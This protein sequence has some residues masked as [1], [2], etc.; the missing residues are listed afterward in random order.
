MTALTFRMHH[1][2]VFNDDVSHARTRA[3][4]ETLNH[5]L[6]SPPPSTTTCPRPGAPEL[7]G[8]TRWV[9]ISGILLHRWHDV[10]YFS[11]KWWEQT[12]VSTAAIGLTRFSHKWT[13]HVMADKSKRMK[14][15][16]LGGYDGSSARL[17]NIIQPNRYAGRRKRMP[18]ICSLHL[19]WSII[20][21]NVVIGSLK[22]YVYTISPKMCVWE[23]GM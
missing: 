13:S 10:I 23:G 14:E 20:S 7:T 21:N 1:A 8:E 2:R 11:S 5:H 18:S 19:H 15:E 4:L 3:Q 16:F 17:L 22:I 6:Q 12:R 9:I